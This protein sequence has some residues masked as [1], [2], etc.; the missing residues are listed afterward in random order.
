MK[1]FVVERRIKREVFL[2]EVLEEVLWGVDL[3][4]DALTSPEIQRGWKS[5][6]ING[7]IIIALINEA[8]VNAVGKLKIRNWEEN[9][10]SRKKFDE[11]FEIFF[12][13]FDKTKRPLASVVAVREIRNAFAHAK[14]ILEETVEEQVVLEVGSVG[15]LFDGL[16]HSAEAGVTVQSYRN[17]RFDSAEFRRTLLE[18]SGV[19]YWDI[20]TKSEES[21]RFLRELD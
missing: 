18:R 13:D 11:F 10:P 16:V 4:F 3:R 14:P 9:R 21:T 12:S 5:E 19:S 2:H 1:K 7:L 8:L 17:I 20:K 6:A 15:N